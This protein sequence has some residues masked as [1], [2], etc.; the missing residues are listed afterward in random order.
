MSEPTA[1]QI[2]DRSARANKATR[3]ALAAIL[4][5]EALVVLLVPRAIAHTSTG[6][7]SLKTTLLVVLAA[8]MVIAGALLRRSWGIAVGSVL[9][10]AL[11]ATGLLTAAMLVLG[12]AFAGIWLYLLKLRHELVGTP[13]GLKMLGS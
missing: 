6:L 10:L 12:L 4:M 13:G 5:L 11:I 3:R 1:R 7:D 8:L 2:A 9:Q